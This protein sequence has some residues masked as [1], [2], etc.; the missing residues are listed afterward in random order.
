MKLRSQVRIRVPQ[1]CRSSALAVAFAATAC[2]DRTTGLLTAPETGPSRNA[3]KV[4]FANVTA[5]EYGAIPGDGVDDSGAIEKAVRSARTVYIPAGE[6]TVSQIITVPSKTRIYGD[7]AVSRLTQTVANFPVFQVLGYGPHAD[8]I[9]VESLG[10]RGTG[11][12]EAALRVV[13]GRHI[14]FRNNEVQRMSMFV[15]TATT[16]TFEGLSSDIEVSDNTGVGPSGVQAGVS[17]TNSRSVTVFRNKVRDYANGIQWWGGDSDPANG[18]APAEAFKPVRDLYISSNTVLNSGHP[19]IPGSGA[20]IWGSMG[21]NIR[22][23]GNYVENCLDVC[24]DAEGSRNVQFVENQASNAANAVLAVFFKSDNIAF[25]GNIVRQGNGPAGY[26][27]QVL[28]FT[29]NPQQEPDGINIRVENNRFEYV[30]ASGAGEVWKEASHEF[31]FENNVLQNTVVSMLGNN[32]R[33][34]RVR[35]NRITLTRETQGKDAIAVGSNHGHGAF[36][37]EVT[38]NVVESAVM[39]RPGVRGIFVRQ[40]LPYAAVRSTIAGNRVR[41]FDNAVAVLAE[42]TQ[43][44]FRIDN[45]D[46]VGSVTDL[47]RP[48]FAVVSPLAKYDAHMA[49]IG[50]MPAVEDGRTVGATDVLWNGT[51]RDM[52]ALRIRLGDLLGGVGVCYQTRPESLGWQPEVCD[53]AISGTTGQ[54]RPLYGVRVRLRT[55]SPGMRVC[56]RV[57]LGGRGWTPEACDGATAGTNDSVV[58]QAIQLRVVR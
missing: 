42:N 15:S 40:W 21:E 54:A 46:L 7:G 43:H 13:N 14:K 29:R 27:G 23:F 52:Q 12:E 11:H 38:G 44:T 56:Y 25:T 10:F 2:S 36:E 16:A 33:N 1:F 47:S 24:L 37:A 19:S 17:I 49:D 28:F 4:E 55:P 9:T 53:G 51:Y 18:A 20:G 31:T 8:S 35:N 45:N 22:V 48:G 26:T 58:V 30:G 57:Y 32:S 5:P 39:Q 41:G 3:A 34:T 50:W 6:Y